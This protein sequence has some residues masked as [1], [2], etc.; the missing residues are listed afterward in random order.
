MSRIRPSHTFATH[1]RIATVA[2]AWRGLRIRSAARDYSLRH[3]VAHYVVA[4]VPEQARALLTDFAWLQARLGELPDEAEPL[5][6]DAAAT[7]GALPAARRAEF[8]P[9][10]TFLRERAHLLRRGDAEWPANRILLQVAV[11]HADE[12][13]VTQAAEAWLA[14]GACDWP[15]MRRARGQRRREARQ[16][17][18]LAVLEHRSHVRGAVV[19]TSGR[20]VT[21]GRRPAIWQIGRAAPLLEL[22]GHAGPVTG[23]CELPDGRLLTWSFDTTLRVWDVTSGAMLAV[24]GGHTDEVLG[25]V[26]LSHDRVLSWSRDGTLRL[27]SATSGRAFVSLRGHLGHVRGAVPLAGGR[28]VTWAIGSDRG[29]DLRLRASDHALLVWDFS[30]M[31]DTNATTP[32]PLR[33]EG[34]AKV[35]RGALD[36]ADGRVLSWALDGSVRVWDGATGAPLHVFASPRGAA[37]D[38]ARGRDPDRDPLRGA[39]RRADGRVIGWDGHGDLWAFDV[40]TGSSRAIPREAGGVDGAV[41]LPAA[42]IASW[43]RDGVIHVRDP[44]SNAVL[45]RVYTGGTGAMQM[46]PRSDGSL[47]VWSVPDGLGV[48]ADGLG[49]TDFTAVRV[50]STVMREADAPDK[51]RPAEITGVLLLPE[52]R[53][54]GGSDDGTLEIRDLGTGERNATVA[55]HADAVKG[56]QHVDDDRLVTWST[57]SSVHLRDASTG[58]AIAVLAGHS[59][60]VL[61]VLP[62][63]GGRLL[64]WADDDTLRL[65][66]TQSGEALAALEGHTG[67]ITGA[68]ELA[69]GRILSWSGDRTVRVWSRAGAPLCTLEARLRRLVRVQTSP[70]G[71]IVAGGGRADRRELRAWD[72]DTLAP[73][74]V[75]PTDEATLYPDVDA[76]QPRHAIDGAFFAPGRIRLVDHVDPDAPRLMACWHAEGLWDTDHL[77]PDGTVVARGPNGLAILHVLNGDRRVSLR[78]LESLPTL[79]AVYAPLPAT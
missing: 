10:A 67:W 16:T 40:D 1:A 32:A 78:A 22:D 21:C 76:P 13:P 15:W 61:D 43:G 12:S 36:L 73:R 46:V 50:W 49:R 70:D 11:E 33:L 77:L 44:D 72:A 19:L 69:D 51:A 31:D 74:A 14:S 29:A 25:A 47:V 71:R 42:R 8:E 65:W 54:L 39:M 35:I 23:A 45:G 52:G 34:H 30:R 64:S 2:H 3:G 7:C 20:V 55:A 68:L 75:L 6:N 58:E 57:D 4:G 62:L 60:S 17:Q 37:S 24:H 27:W 53:V 48:P 26:P 63:S 28:V 66:D 38:G 79:P 59:G 9:W 41:Q 5:T 56:V 18:C